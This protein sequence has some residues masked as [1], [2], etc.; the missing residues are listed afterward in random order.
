MNERKRFVKCV[1]CGCRTLPRNA[2]RERPWAAASSLYMD[3][4]LNEGAL[5]FPCANGRREALGLA[6]HEE[7]RSPVARGFAP[8]ATAT[9]KKVTINKQEYTW[10]LSTL[11]ALIEKWKERQFFD[12]FE[13]A[14]AGWW[15]VVVNDRSIPAADFGSVLISDGDEISIVLG[16]GRYF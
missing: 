8:A 10:E 9:A 2:R 13:K 1:D 12:R 3:G 16:R 14:D 6:I 11:D 5:C 4:R 7:P 15:L